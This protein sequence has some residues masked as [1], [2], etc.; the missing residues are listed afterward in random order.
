MAGANIPLA[1]PGRPAS[2]VITQ[3]PAV[4]FR[5][6]LPG[7]AVNGGMVTIARNTKSM[8][9]LSQVSFGGR[10]RSPPPMQVNLSYQASP[11]ASPMVMR[12]RVPETQISANVP[13]NA[14]PQSRQL[15][16]APSDREPAAPF[17]GTVASGPS[18][19][20][21]LSC[22]APPSVR[23]TFNHVQT[24][25]WP[26]AVRASSADRSSAHV[27]ISGGGTGPARQVS[28]AT[29]DSSSLPFSSARRISGATFP[30]GAS[31]VAPVHRLQP[32]H[33]SVLAAGAPTLRANPM[34]IPVHAAAE[35]PDEVILRQV[36]RLQNSL[37]QQIESTKQQIQRQSAQAGLKHVNGH[38]PSQAA[39]PKPKEVARPLPE[40]R[41]EPRPEPG[42]AAEPD[43]AELAAPPGLAPPGI[44]LS[45]DGT[46]ARA[47]L[48]GYSPSAVA[49]GRIQ[50][51]W[52]RRRM[53]MGKK[54]DKESF[55][56][57]FSD[58]LMEIRKKKQLVPKLHPEHHSAC[59]IQRA[60][61]MSRWRRVFVT[62]CKRDL[63]WLGSLDWLQRH[64]MLYGTELAEP[65]DLDWWYHQQSGAPL[66]YEVDP[67]GCKKLREHLNRM[68][69]GCLP[70]PNEPFLEAKPEKDA[71]RANAR[72][73][74]TNPPM[75]VAPAQH[76]HVLEKVPKKSI[77][78]STVTLG[79]LGRSLLAPAMPASRA[80]MAAIS[81]RVEGRQML[82]AS[83]V[84]LHRCPSPTRAPMV[85]RMAPPPVA[86]AQVPCS[87]ATGLGRA[88]KAPRFPVGQVRRGSLQASPRCCMFPNDRA[89][90]PCL[91]ANC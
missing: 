53:R 71:P 17:R 73:A 20:P 18:L 4:G 74:Q 86:M 45:I 59:R 9:D 60:W 10:A 7:Y 80:T 77:P 70:Q 55:T 23:Q 31:A 27:Q 30:K 64:S 41:P 63:G 14:T 24:A 65:E 56:Q 26:S 40:T 36:T 19:R 15:G 11:R 44:A 88:A 22:R 39:V 1:S 3:S 50:R 89:S 16:A 13:G 61:K 72:A 25:A 85:S 35:Q 90:G 76:S 91:A 6:M 78:A 75:P 28:S 46:I 5:A 42:V 81:P 62:D 49:A 67:W 66:D 54:V 38:M 58:I 83:A 8:C 32:S 84:T 43:T 87:L 33:S 21:G 57:V 51:A 37:M 69:F 82:S 12:G 2:R 48:K 68:W 29:S 34:P 79:R 52:R 47:Y